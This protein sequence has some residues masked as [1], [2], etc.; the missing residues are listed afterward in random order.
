MEIIKQG[1]LSR[2]KDKKYFIC[3]HC[4]CEFIANKSEYKSLGMHLNMMAYGCTCP[5]CK[6]QVYLEE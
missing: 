3:Q 6:K 5:T 1:D 4:G 2:L